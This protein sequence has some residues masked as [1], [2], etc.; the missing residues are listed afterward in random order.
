M[1]TPVSSG[2]LLFAVILS[3]HSR[4]QVAETRVT[5]LAVV[6]DFD[7]FPYRGFSLGAGFIAPL[8]NQFVLQA[9]L[10]NPEMSLKWGKRVCLGGVILGYVNGLKE[11]FTRLIEQASGFIIGLFQGDCIQLLE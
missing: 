6:K 4:C 3:K 8:M 7:V 11:F 9:V 2:L 10:S 1:D 5:P